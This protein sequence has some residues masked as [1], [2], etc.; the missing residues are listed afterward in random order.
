MASCSSFANALVLTPR[1]QY[2]VVQ[3]KMPLDDSAT[4]ATSTTGLTT[5]AAVMGTLIVTCDVL[6]QV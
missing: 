2:I 6:L 1:Y 4:F 3:L 5:S